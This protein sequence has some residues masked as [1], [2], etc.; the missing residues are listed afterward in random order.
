MENMILQPIVVGGQTFK[1]R[2]MFPPLTTGYEKNGM[3]SEQDMGFYTRLAKGGVGYIV[4]GDVA[5]I[6]SFSPTPKLFDD[7]QI[8]AFK[9]LADSVHA[10]GTKLG[11]QLFHPEYDV[12]AINSLFMQKKFDE[13]RQRLHHDMMFFTDEVSEE[14]LMAII[15]KM[16]ACA[17]RAQKAG[18]D[19]IQIHG[20]RL[21]GCLCSTRMNHRTDKFGGSLENRVR[22]ARMLTRAIRKAVPDMI[23]D[24]KLSIVTP[25]RGK[26]G[27]DEADAVQF[28]QWLVEDGVDMFHVAQ[29]NHTGNMADT[30]PPMGVQP[31]G[32]FV[33]IA[34][35]IKK[36]VNVPVSAVGRIVDA[37]MAERVIE[38]G[39][40]D[41]VA[42]GRPLLADPDWGTKIA[43]GKACDIRRCI[44]C[45]KGCTDAIQNRQFLSCVLNAENGYENSRSIQPAEQKKKIAVLGGGPAGLEAARVAALRGHDVTLFEKT[46][47]LGGQLNIACVPPRKEEM[48][49]ATQ[50]LIHA[51]CN[52]G[53]HLCMGQ[54][55]TAEQLKD[56]GFEAVI[57]AVGAHSA[58]PR[59]PG[60]DGVNVADAWKVLAGEQQVYGT[61]AVI[62]GGMVGCETAEYLAAR[63]CKVSVIEMMDKIAAG[64]STTILPTLLENYK[65]Y[66]V[67]QY[68]SHKVK[69]FRM[70]AVVCEN[71]DGAEVTIPCDYIVL[72]MGA[73]S[74]EFD[75]AALEAAN[76]PVYSIGD[77]A[78]KAADI[79]NAIR[80][81]YDTACQL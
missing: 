26:G 1:N 19:V 46:T 59:I 17:V 32:F 66:G 81:G 68:P 79:S 48:R 12:D 39:M 16:C 61:V 29:A 37:E 10:Y 6:N 70:D 56:A 53:V 14:M 4:L 62:G 3:I 47:S 21:N 2:I 51:V 50:D 25:Q 54:T 49:R 33:R 41:I 30:I 69:E 38:S 57:N 7:S 45:N 27:I 75:A 55:R 43:A 76:I 72:A 13:M 23:I 80:T 67:E 63:G 42:M 34:G 11:V 65:T 77:A 5:P 60:I 8:P 9:E 36:A 74:N 78:G 31:Y 15:D 40:A 20:D 28:A 18:V 71:K 24:Y 64:E 35:D 73:R 22:F 44:S 52:A 58:A